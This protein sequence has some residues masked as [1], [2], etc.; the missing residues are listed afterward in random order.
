MG[1]DLTLMPLI[2]D[3]YWTS[4]E[5]WDVTRRHELWDAIRELETHPV[6]GDFTCFRATVGEDEFRGYGI[7]TKDPY[8]D[9]LRYIEASVL[10]S[11]AGH[12]CV[13]DNW[14]NIGLWNMLS[15]MPS[16]YPIVLYWH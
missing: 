12:D 6:P 9:N 4:H 16:D 14:K 2:S 10:A 3:N 1:V 8:G 5:L 15:R 11:I 13:Q 7:I